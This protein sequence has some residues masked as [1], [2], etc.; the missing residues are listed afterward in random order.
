LSLVAAGLALVVTGSVAA[1]AAAGSGTEPDPTINDVTELCQYRVTATALNFRN[2]PGIHAEIEYRLSRYQT[3]LATDEI[4]D[5]AF[6]PYHWRRIGDDN[7]AA[8]EYMA[9]T[10]EPCRPL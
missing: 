5:N 8:N 1:V 6:D 2:A 7:Y 9:R 10:S 3:F 4:W